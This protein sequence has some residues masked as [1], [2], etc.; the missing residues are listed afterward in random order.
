MNANLSLI[1]SMTQI[2]TILFTI[3]LL[4]SQIIKSADAQVQQGLPSVMP[5]APTQPPVKPKT[6]PEPALK[7]MGAAGIT[8]NKKSP[9]PAVAAQRAVGTAAH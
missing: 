8:G 9:S 6:P 7:S 4:S 5:S 2:V 3:A 1:R